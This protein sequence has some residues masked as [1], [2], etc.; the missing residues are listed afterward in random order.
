VT[1][2]SM[3]EALALAAALVTAGGVLDRAI[4]RH[5]PPEP[6]QVA[7]DKTL[8]AWDRETEEACR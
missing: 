7:P 4:A 5:L 6:R 8:P 2:L 1:A 3:P